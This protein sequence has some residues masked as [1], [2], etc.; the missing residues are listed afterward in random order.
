MANSYKFKGVALATVSETALLTAAST[1]TII[2]RSIR[3]TNNTSNTPTGS[4]GTPS[5]TYSG[6]TYY[7]PYKNILEASATTWVYTN[8]DEI[9]IEIGDTSV[10]NIVAGHISATGGGLYKV[11]IQQ[12]RFQI[13]AS[14]E[15][16]WTFAMQFVS[17]S[18]DDIV[19]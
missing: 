12:C 14:K 4:R 16:R 10:G 15:D 18:R 7:F 11:A 13:D 17:K 5:F 8:A 2:I 19:F 9:E 6:Q 3:V 1:E